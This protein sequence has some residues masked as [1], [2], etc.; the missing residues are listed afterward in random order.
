MYHLPLL[1]GYGPGSNLRSSAPPAPIPSP[2]AEY[3]IPQSETDEAPAELAY[4][5]AP[6][7]TVELDGYMPST[8]PPLDALSETE[9]LTPNP[10]S[11]GTPRPAARELA[12]PPD[13][14]AIAEAVFLAYGVVVFFGLDESQERNI[15]EDVQ[16]AG[17]M[18]KALKEDRW[19]IEECHYEVCGDVC[20]FTLRQSD[21]FAV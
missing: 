10:P 3:P 15:L 11:E 12:P 19:E 14:D 2:A 20:P 4:F 9:M 17:V 8:S 21:L 16:S 18:Q 6:T 5:S 7:R 13:P 1:P